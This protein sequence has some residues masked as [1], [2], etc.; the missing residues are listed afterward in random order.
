V[1]A[2][3][4]RFRSTYE[5]GVQSPFVLYAAAAYERASAMLEEAL[6]EGGPWI[7][8][9]QLTL[10]DIN[11]MPYA[12]RLDYLGLLG[13]WFNGRPRTT[14]WWEDGLRSKR[15]RALLRRRRSAEDIREHLYPRLAGGLKRRISRWQSSDNVRPVPAHG[16]H[17]VGYRDNAR[18]WHSGSRRNQLAGQALQ[19]GRVSAGVHRLA[20]WLEPVRNWGAPEN[21]CDDLSI[22]SVAKRSLKPDINP[23]R[24]ATK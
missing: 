24:E 15:H 11:L 13:L 1:S 7:L 16:S 3:S 20:V 10:A 19:R 17:I 8:G 23:T 6:A 21:T 4:G 5:F 9:D 18:R 22:R 14:A 2:G 12:A